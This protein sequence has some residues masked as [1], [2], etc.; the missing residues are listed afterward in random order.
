[1]TTDLDR[2]AITTVRMLALDAVEKA[3]SGH[4]GL[5]LGAAPLAYTIFMRHLRFDPKTPD[6][7]GRDRF[8]LSAGHGSMLLYSL[9]HLAGYDLPREELE[10]F[11]QFGSKTPGHPEYGMTPG[12]ETTTGP[13]GQGL[14]TGV[15]MALGMR[16]W[17][18]RL[19]S[20]ET[21]LM[22]ARVFGIVSDGDLMEGISHEAASLAGHLGLGNLIYVYDQNHISIEGSTDLA[23][24]ENVA[25]R[26][27]AYGWHVLEVEDVE[28]VDGIDKCLGEAIVDPRPSLLMARTH[29]GFRSPLQDSEKVHGSAMGK[30]A[31]MKTREAYGWPADA[32]FFVPEEVRTHFQERARRGQAMRAEWESA[33]QAFKE[34]DPKA[35]GIF[36]RAMNRD[37][38]GDFEESLP[39]FQ[40]S[41]GPLATRQASGK[42]LNAL[43]R[44]LPELIGGSADLA[45]STETWLVGEEA[46]GPGAFAGRNIHFG[47]REHAMGAA[48][49]GLALMGFRSFGGTFLIFSDYMRPAIRLA[50]L[51]DLPVI[52]VF[53]HDSI[54]LGED[55]PTHQP[56]EQAMSLRLIPNLVVLRPGDAE[57]TAQAW[58]QALKRKDG[59]TALLLTRQKL[60][61][62]DRTV[63]APARVGEGAYALLEEK[64]PQ[65]ILAA[66]GSEV[67]IALE[68]AQSLKSEGIR[69][70]LVSVPS[71]E[72]LKKRGEAAQAALFPPGI[73]S[74]SVEAGVTLG[75]ERM[76]THTLGIDH[77]GASGPY[78]ELY[79]AF[80]ITAEAVA[81]RAK[82]ILKGV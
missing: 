66:S 45:P 24:T 2:L 36:Q 72:L 6:W 76:V 41:D 47:V 8:I 20:A 48:L 65:I 75:W 1:M 28:D 27:R 35:A 26:F 11:R 19:K 21:P 60:P 71:F 18:E 34:K 29:I 30:Q 73:P 77:F 17:S 80:G 52:Y 23:F 38:P 57:E 39:H 46:V 43:A 22:D 44:V 42:T 13:L 79:R 49:N 63:L 68:A 58:A 37:L 3:K 59:P 54:G 14:A 69:V 78:E 16:L 15:G 53:T 40:P 12:V 51:M 70:R 55:G 25:A 5:P 74:L 56:I 81:G 62:F 32:S 61:T 82:Q 64:S 7:P 9:L 4:P 33:F 67:S 10:R 31:Q 50:A